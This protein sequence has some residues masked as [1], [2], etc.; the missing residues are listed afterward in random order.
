[1]RTARGI[2]R[3]AAWACALGLAAVTAS[4][5]T[6]GAD[7]GQSSSSASA[8][9]SASATAGGTDTAENCDREASSPAPKA[10]AVDGADVQAIKNRGYIRVGVSA[11]Q[12]LTGY[13]NS[14]GN[15]E[16]FDIDLAHALAQ[17]LFGDPGKVRFTAIST[18]DRQKALTDGT[19]DVVIDTMTITCERLQVVSFSAVYFEA[20]QRLLVA[21]GSPYTS[22][23]ALKGQS[24]C[25]QDGSTSVTQIAA[26][27]ATPDTVENVSDCL[28]KLQENT[29]S[30]ISTDDTLLAGLAQQDPNL[31]VVGPKLEPE[32]YGIAMPLHKTDLEQWVNYVLAQYEA[33]GGWEASYQKWFLKS[34]GAAQPPVA[35]YSH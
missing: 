14:A 6:S 7:G 12:Y 11:D 13:L 32:P 34:L 23:K 17:A 20:S 5:C 29:V 8:A 1:M 19:V 10:S 3:A 4:A 24:V 27:G 28:V 26:A 30:A 18:A 25:A 9:P 21:K 31:V 2:R 22:I 15:E 35:Q 33:D 16:G